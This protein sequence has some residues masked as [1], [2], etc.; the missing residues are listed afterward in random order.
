MNAVTL[1]VFPNSGITVEG[2]NRYM[3]YIDQFLSEQYISQAVRLKAK[4]IYSEER[5]KVLNLD[6][7]SER[8]LYSVKNDI[9]NEEFTVEVNAFNSPAITAKCA[10]PSPS[11][12]MHMLTVLNDLRMRTDDLPTNKFNQEETFVN[13]DSI[14]SNVLAGHYT[15]PKDL[16]QANLLF[17]NNKVVI[18]QAKNGLVN[19]SVSDK[20][21]TFLV[22]LNETVDRNIKTSCR[23]K[24]TESALCVH[25]VATFLQL[26]SEYGKNA[27]KKIRNYDAE[28]EAL[29]RFCR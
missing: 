19:A 7:K 9:G 1:R 20:D 25:K 23:C 5:Y 2:D 8:A 29:L 22:V 17:R 16:K 6:L 12:C 26:E 27:F 14:I 28:K 21:Y 13:G 24:H 10:C 18:N 3:H 15:S 11:F 4:N